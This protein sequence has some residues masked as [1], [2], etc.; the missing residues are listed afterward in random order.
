LKSREGKIGWMSATRDASSEKE[1]RIAPTK[2]T[3]KDYDLIILGSAR[4][5]KKKQTR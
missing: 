3:P 4:N 1:T 5:A 2:Q